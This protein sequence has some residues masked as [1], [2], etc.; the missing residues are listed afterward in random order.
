MRVLFSGNEAIAFGAYMAGVTIAVGYPGNPSTEILECLAKYE[1]VDASWAPNE[2]VA[3]EIGI[4]ASIAGARVL[5]PMKH[6]GLNVAA[7][8]LFMLAYIGVNGGIVIISSD[9]PGMHNSQ[10]EQDNRH[11]A[12]AAKIPMLEP[13]D[14]QEAASLIDEAFKISEHFDTPILIRMTSRIDFSK[15]L[16][17]VNTERV[18]KEV[19][20]EK[21]TQKHVMVP[22]NA[23]SRR[24]VL[25][26]RLVALTQF[27]DEFPENR[28]EWGSRQIGFITSGISYH[29]VK[30]VFPEASVLKLTM[31][32]PLPKRLIADFIDQVEKVAVIEELDAYIE[33]Q[34]KAWGLPVTG[35]RYISSIGELNPDIIRDAFES[36]ENSEREEV[37]ELELPGRPPVLCAGCPNRGVL[38]VLKKMGPVVMGDI[39]CSTLGLMPNMESIDT[40]TCM[41][42]SIGNAIGFQKA[43][44]RKDIVAVI[45]DSAFIHSGIN[46]LIDIVC[47]G[48]ITT[49]IILDNRSN[50]GTDQEHLRTDGLTSGAKNQEL[51]FES[52]I[53][54]IGIESVREINPYDLEA[55]TQVIT[56]EINKDE[57]SIIISRKPCLLVE[58][59]KTYPLMV[60]DKCNGCKLCLELECPSISWE[61]NR[62][63]IESDTCVGCG[64]CVQI[65]SED[66]IVTYECADE[67]AG[68]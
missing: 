52:L 21:D 1:D 46:S 28:V 14:S 2:K 59:P 40:F 16:V 32:N 50:E 25:E 35:K 26:N 15:S 64:V 8:P 62:A 10:N 7:D 57:P 54:A 67:G 13:S 5:V 53:R 12:R 19:G 65:C 61:E 34:I 63:R 48:G 27:S 39:G 55:I 66:A 37:L 30:E 45:G 36:K 4:G 47:N 23:R 33:D 56:E 20:Y 68:I 11:Y 58:E 31:T 17:E 18:K 3:L 6:V 42:A 49:V 41:G 22:A 60:I 43:T 24:E 9:D 38:H 29:Y 44:G 51:V